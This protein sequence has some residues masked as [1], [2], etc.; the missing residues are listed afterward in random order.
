MTSMIVFLYERGMGGGGKESDYRPRGKHIFISLEKVKYISS[1]IGI[2][3]E[4]T[5]AK[6]D[7]GCIPPT[8]HT[9]A[10]IVIKLTYTIKSKK[11]RWNETEGICVSVER[12]NGNNNLC[13]WTTTFPTSQTT[14]ANGSTG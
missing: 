6:R 4:N 2:I 11:V 9:S 5:R 10:N 1:M 7:D 3:G 14:Y 12:R 13:T 8:K